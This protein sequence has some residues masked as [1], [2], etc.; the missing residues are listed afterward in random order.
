[1]EPEKKI[2]NPPQ[3]APDM[4]IVADSPIPSVAVAQSPPP[5][6]HISA[7]LTNMAWSAVILMAIGGFTALFATSQVN[8]TALASAFPVD[9]L[10]I[11]VALDLFSR[12]VAQTGALDAIGQRL[13]QA[14]NG[15]P[16]LATVLMGLLMFASSALLNNLAAIFI[17]A[18]IFLTLLRAMRAPPRVTATFL[19]LMLVLCNLGG[20]ATPMGDFPAI[21]LMSSGLVGFM[22]YLK[23]A[24]PLAASLALIAILFYSALIRRQHAAACGRD[25][26]ARTRIYLKLTSVHNRHSNPNLLRAILLTVVFA[27]M[28]LAWALI[29]PATWPFFMTALIGVAV[30]GIIAGPRLGAEVIGQY[31]LKTLITMTIILCMAALVSVSGVVQVVANQLVATVPDGTL[32]LVALMTLVAIAA[33]LFSAGPATAAVLPI[34]ITLSEG[35]LAQY[36]NLIGIAFAASICAGSSM[37]LHSATAGPTLRG[38]AVK[39]GFVGKNGKAHWGALPYLGYGALTAASQLSLSIAWI[40][41]AAENQYAW[42][43]NLVPIFLLLAVGVMVVRQAKAARPPKS[44]PTIA[45]SIS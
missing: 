10:A 30:A 35:P 18:P 3:T 8:F 34:F 43:L 25:D 21:L 33:G 15:S 41:F 12:F 5:Q 7:K 20:M 27:G 24:F 36:G 42:V 11:L 9:V 39:A 4:R 28:V 19:S 6:R 26:K 23:G 14:T 17:L 44:T 13:A 37:F 31:D 45:T 1:M 2:E 32:L 22:P 38:E 16:E 29:P 40:L